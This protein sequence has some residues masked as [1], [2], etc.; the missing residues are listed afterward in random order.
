MRSLV[1]S[2]LPAE[3]ADLLDWQSL[4]H[5]K[6]S[7]IDSDLRERFSDLLLS[8]SRKSQERLQAIKVSSW[9]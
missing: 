5:E 3:V 6:E 1:E 9:R 4:L 8:V 7:L 2:Y